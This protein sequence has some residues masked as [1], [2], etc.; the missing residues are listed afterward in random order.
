MNEK[1][2]VCGC[3]CSVCEHFISSKC[4]GCS[5]IEGKV[6]WASFTSVEIC[7]IYNCVKNER[8]LKNCGQ[9][10]KIPCNIWRELK[11]PSYTDEQHEAGIDQRVAALKEINN[12]GTSPI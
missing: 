12:L 11:D 10:S 3:D 5:K 9:C 7:P 4:S 6:Y 1:V 2:S 8:K